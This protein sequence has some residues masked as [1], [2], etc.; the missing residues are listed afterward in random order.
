MAS[1]RQRADK[2]Q[3][4]VTRKGFP[5]VVQSF[6][7]RSEAIRWARQTEAAMDQGA[8]RQVGASDGMTLRELLERYAVEVSPR[9]RGSRDEVIRIRAMQRTKMAG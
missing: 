3:A 5:A 4:R 1:I 7:T 6:A 8:F 9:K 2:W